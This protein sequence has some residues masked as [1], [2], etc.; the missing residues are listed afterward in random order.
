VRLVYFSM[1]SLWGF[2]IGTLGMLGGLAALNRPLEPSAPIV[3][4][5]IGAA[6]LALGGGLVVAAAYREATGR[7]S[8]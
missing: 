7:G 5:V 4:V 8:R 1:A 2:L 3:G 6:L